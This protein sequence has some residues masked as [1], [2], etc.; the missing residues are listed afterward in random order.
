MKNTVATTTVFS[1]ALCFA[2]TSLHGADGTQ[3]AERP[4]ILWITAEDLS[5]LIGC[6]GDEFATTP[7]IDQLA[8]EGVRYTNAFAMASVC[9]PARSCLITG[10]YPVTLGTQSLRSVVPMPDKIR[11]FSEYLRDA[12]YY[13]TNNVKEDYQFKTPPTAWNESSNKAHWRNG[14]KGKP[15]FSVFNTMLT[16]QSRVRMRGKQIAAQTKTLPDE[17]RHSVDTVPVP[18]YYPDTPEVRRDMAN[19]HDLVTA[20]DLWTAGL[21]KELEEDGLADNTIVFFYSDHGTGMPRHKRWLYDSGLH[22]PLIVRFPKKYAHLSPVAA[23]ES[24]DRLVSFVDFA[25]TVLSLVG[26]EIPEYMQGTAFLGAQAGE[27]RDCVFA[28]RDRVD[29]VIEVSR[30][31]RT[32][33]YKYIRNYMPHR[34]VMQV[35]DFSERGPTRQSLRR[36]GEAGQLKGTTS[37]LLNA[38]KPAEELFDLSKDPLEL[39]N[40]ANDPAHQQVLGDLRARLR[41]WMLEKR[42]TGFLPEGEIYSRCRDGQ[43]PYEMAAQDE[44]YPLEKILAAA[45]LVGRPGA[46]PELA[47]AL[48]A[49][50][51]AVRYWGAV[52]LLAMGV[53]AEPHRRALEAALADS[54]PFVQIT[55]AEALAH[56]GE[57]ETTLPVLGNALLSDDAFARLYAAASVKYLGPVAS[58]LVPQAKE[59]MTKKGHVVDMYTP[60]AL[61]YFLSLCP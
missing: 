35:G 28:V 27:P 25:P 15:F 5:P 38:S 3:S 37:I 22:V 13:C 24:T 61:T 36:L 46:G 11:C 47:A 29:E 48:K 53:D 57:K 60:W 12:G 56:L 20:M 52:G 4:N 16:H 1:L 7:N 39:H 49:D 51:S 42:D 26:L 9:S 50:D 18:P 8:R 54:S 31:V 44:L 45:E 10:V 55:V 58:P 21:L 32:D 43:V 6:Y 41:R 33:R 34:P 17:L 2:A 59:A 19:L 14:A 40:L 23:G 30:A